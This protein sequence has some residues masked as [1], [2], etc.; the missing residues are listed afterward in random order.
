MNLGAYNKAYM[1][2]IPVDMDC[3]TTISTQFPKRFDEEIFDKDVGQVFLAP[4]Y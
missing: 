2:V 1:E 4:C 3:S